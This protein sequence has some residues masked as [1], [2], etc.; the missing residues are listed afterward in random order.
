M[1]GYRQAKATKCGGMGHGKSERLM[2]PRKPGNRPH[3]TRWREAG[4]EDTDLLEGQTMGASRPENVSTKLQQ[5]AKLAREAPTMVLTTLA[6]HIDLEFLHEAYRQTRKDG[7]TGVD[8]QTAEEYATDLEGNL[9]RLLDSFKAGSYRAPPVRRVHIPKDKGGSRPIGIPTFEDKVLQRAVAMVLGA[10][11]EQ[12]FLDCSYGFRPGRSQHQALEA[13]RKG[14]SDMGGGW[15]ID[16]DVQDFFGTLDFG[17]LRSFLDQRVRDGVLRRSIGKW[18]KAG[19]MEEGELRRSESGTPQGGVISPLLANVYLHEVL[20]TW[21]EQQVK[22]RLQGRSLMVRFADDAVIVCADERDANRVMGVLPKRFAR[23]G[24]TV[25]P[26]K[27]RKVDFQRPNS[28]SGP[29]GGNPSGP[30]TFDFLGFTHFWG[31]TRKGGWAVKKK[32]AKDRFSRAVG[33]IAQWCR[34][35]RHKPIA[36]QHRELSRKLK[37]HDAYYGVTGNCRALQ[38][39]RETTRHAWRKWLDRRGG[40]RSMSWERFVR[41]LSRYPLPPARVVHSVYRRRCVANP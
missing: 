11:Y 8:G 22:P 12:D 15:V 33:R 41:L 6:H 37:G 29:R 16:M 3:G 14:L 39:L 23:F 38:R 40:K 7:A 1:R 20:D 17:H 28:R 31:R 9:G 4:A 5:I 21:F 25:H 30:G 35:W 2:V 32:T 27:T 13:L 24:L 26:K 10:V 18:L 34:R 19:V 36:E